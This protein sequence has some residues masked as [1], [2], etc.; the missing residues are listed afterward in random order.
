MTLFVVTAFDNEQPVPAGRPNPNPSATST[1]L[2]VRG[3]VILAKVAETVP[4]CATVN[5]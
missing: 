2:P 3:V 5:E 4:A 1:A